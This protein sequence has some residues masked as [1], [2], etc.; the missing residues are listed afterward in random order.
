MDDVE[1]RLSTGDMYTD[2]SDLEIGYDGSKEQLV[3]LRFTDINVP[4]GANVT[5]AYLEFVADEIDTALTNANIYAVAED[6][7]SAFTSIDYNLSSRV[8]MQASVNWDVPPWLTEGETYRSPDLSEVVQ[9]IIDRSGWIP[10]NAMAFVISGSGERTAESFEGS[11]SQATLLHVEYI[12]DKAVVID[13]LPNDEDNK[14]YPNQ[15]GKFAVVIMDNPDFDTTQIDPSTLELGANGATPVGPVEF[16]DADG[17]FDV[18]LQA[19]F[20]MQNTGILCNDTEV[21]L[22]GETYSGVSFSGTDL[23][24]A[25]QCETGGCHAY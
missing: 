18:D 20:A 6:N 5:R 7:V 25:T 14:V 1:E 2:S 23:L 21:S 10:G 3:G 11:P 19:K 16:L 9:S 4:N 15:S 22:T 13:V 24:D 17:A 8:L 12:F